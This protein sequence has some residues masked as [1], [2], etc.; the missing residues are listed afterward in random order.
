MGL[1]VLWSGALG[2]GFAAVAVVAA[3]ELSATRRL[4]YALLALFLLL[5]ALR[6]GYELFRRLRRKA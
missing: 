4:V 3:D 1:F 5:I 6:T 2:V